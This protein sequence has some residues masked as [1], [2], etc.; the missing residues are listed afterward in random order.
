MKV[1]IKMAQFVFK[2]LSKLTP[3]MGEGGYEI[4]HKNFTFS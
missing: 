4:P 3:G 2:Y 1:T